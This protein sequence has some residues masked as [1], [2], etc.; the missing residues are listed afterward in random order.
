MLPSPELGGDALAD[1]DDWRRLR[2]LCVERLR[3]QVPDVF[4]A[5]RQVIH[6]INHRLSFLSQWEAS[7]VHGALL[8]GRRGVTRRGPHPSSRSGLAL[9][10]S[11]R[12][13]RGRA[14]HRDSAP[15]PSEN[16]TITLRTPMTEAHWIHTVNGPEQRSCDEGWRRLPAAIAGQASVCAESSA[17][18]CAFSQAKL[19]LA[20]RLW[21]FWVRFRSDRADRG[22]G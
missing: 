3:S 15:R 11:T 19:E 9:G 18:P 8:R 1:V 6:D 7:S 10:V 5:A 16:N 21:R 13:V 17:G 4:A 12:C 2:A 20:R 14:G 22:C